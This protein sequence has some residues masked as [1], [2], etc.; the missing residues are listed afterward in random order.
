MNRYKVSLLALILP[1]FVLAIGVPVF[2]DEDLSS[3]DSTQSESAKEAAK[4]TREAAK[5]EAEQKREDAKQAAEVKRE[6]AKQAAEVKR[7]AAKQELETKK[8]KLKEDKLKIC[9]ERKDNISGAMSSAASR[10]QEKITLFGQIADRTQSFYTSKG[11][12]LSNYDELVAV[13][14]S[15]K[16]AALAAVDNVKAGSDDFVCDGDNPKGV[17]NLFKADL[18]V[19][20]EALKSYRTAVKDLIV[21]VKSVQ[22]TEGE[23]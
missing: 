8:E 6:A 5:K 11:K 21:G 23:S 17:A 1:F 19:M 10:G 15:Q 14:G 7:E 4:K 12:V 9:E 18:E 13:V 20:N 16:A 2:A 3:S 22:S